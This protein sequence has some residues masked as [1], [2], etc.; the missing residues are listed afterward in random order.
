MVMQNGRVK[1]GAPTAPNIVLKAPNRPAVAAAPPALSTMVA[2]EWQKKTAVPMLV[3]QELNPHNPIAT[4]D[5][6]APHSRNPTNDPTVLPMTACIA[7][8]GE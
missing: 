8:L 4:S 2:G 1:H 3:R 5:A 7:S 6:S